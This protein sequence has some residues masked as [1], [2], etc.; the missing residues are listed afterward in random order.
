MDVESSPPPLSQRERGDRV[1]KDEYT[2]MGLA[3]WVARALG[4]TILGILIF[5]GFLT[6]LVVNN[7]SS[8]LFSADF[9]TRILNEQDVYNRIYDE[10]L[11]GDRL[12]SDTRGLLG[13]IQL[14]THEE[15]VRLLREIITPEYL[16]GQ[17]QENIHRFID[18]LNEDSDRLELYV[19]LGPP[20]QR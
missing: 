16:Q 12:T 9:Y 1:Y 15:I 11:L 5:L 2:N 14:V 19:E 4:S 8:K 17:V 13:D 20:W 18:Y 3:L 6:L 7:F 10:V